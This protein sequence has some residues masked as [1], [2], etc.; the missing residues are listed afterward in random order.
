MSTLQTL[1]LLVHGP[2]KQ[3][4]TT[5][6]ATAPKPM[7]IVDAEGGSKFL[8]YKMLIWDP[9]RESPPVPSDEWEICVVV[10]REWV[11]FQKVYDWL[12]SGQH[13]FKSVVIDSI[14]ELQRRCKEN[15]STDAFKIQDW[16][17]LLAWMDR[18]I[19]G[20]R[21]L[22]LIPGNPVEVVVFVAE[23]RMKDGRWSP[24]MQ[25]QIEVSLPYWMDLVGYLFAQPSQNPDGTSGELVR[26]LLISPHPTYV[27]GERVAGRL[28]PV[29]N[30]PNLTDMFA[31]IYPA[32]PAPA[33]KPTTPTKTAKD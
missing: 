25:G 7:L 11:Q 13:G 32:A 24:M 17:V 4:K 14:T 21:D 26:Q 29:V 27:T 18:A 10:T 28:P 1:S 3:G 23:T 20:V 15:I 5:M 19:R 31:S 33:T 6:A 12:A 30:T 9:L 22:T 8:P 2:S 16:G